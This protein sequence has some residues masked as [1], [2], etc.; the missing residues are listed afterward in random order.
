MGIKLKRKDVI[1]R[2][3]FLVETVIKDQDRPLR[4]KKGKQEKQ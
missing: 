4:V 1:V 3:K 2:V